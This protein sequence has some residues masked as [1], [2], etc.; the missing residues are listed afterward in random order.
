MTLRQLGSASEIIDLFGGT[1]A[2]AKL[3]GRT[4]QHVSNYRQSGRLPADTFLLIKR[5]LAKHGCEAPP[6]IWGIAEPASAEPDGPDLIQASADVRVALPLIEHLR[7]GGAH[8]LAY[9]EVRHIVDGLLREVP[10]FGYKLSEFQFFRGRIENKKRLLERPDEFSYPKPSERGGRCHRLGQ[11]IFYGARNLDTVLAELAPEP[12][13]LVHV[14]VATVRPGRS[15]CITAIGEF[16]HVR[17]YDRALIGNEEAVATARE[18]LALP[19]GLRTTVVDAFFADAFLTPAR[20]PRDYNITAAL[21]ELLLDGHNPFDGFAYPSV[22]HRGGLNVVVIPERFDTI[23]QWDHFMAFE[24][25]TYLGF[26][27]YGRKQYGSAAPPTNG[28]IGWE[29]L[30]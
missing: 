5:E 7:G 13:D 20:Q 21:S 4:P 10:Y 29:H 9:H 2:T 16:D 28:A 17:R 12:G 19:V 14:G 25:T 27:I 18:H 6:S 23:L 15:V 1:S 8:R 3:I 24:I 26:G 11:T 30:R 22:A